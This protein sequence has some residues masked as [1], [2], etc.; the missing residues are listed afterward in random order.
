MSESTIERNWTKIGEETFAGKISREAMSAE[1]ERLT[2]QQ[3]PE[4]GTLSVAFSPGEAIKSAIK[5]LRLPKVSAIATDGCIERPG[6]A[7]GLYGIEANYRNGRA[8]IYG[9]DSGTELTII[10]SDFEPKEAA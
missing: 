2:W 3:I 8:W 1:I 7:Y 6:A 4:S 10:R 9:I 5:E